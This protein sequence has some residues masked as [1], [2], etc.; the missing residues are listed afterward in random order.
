MKRPS[1]DFDLL[2]CLVIFSQF[3]REHVFLEA[4]EFGK[5]DGTVL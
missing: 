4:T 3:L 5:K 2:V 1:D